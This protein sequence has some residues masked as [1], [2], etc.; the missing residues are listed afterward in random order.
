MYME[1]L[2]DF[3]LI[4]LHVILKFSKAHCTLIYSNLSLLHL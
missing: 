2:S 1:G 4:Q 3:A